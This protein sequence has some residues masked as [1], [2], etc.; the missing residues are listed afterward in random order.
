MAKS[1]KY[2][3]HVYYLYLKQT[4]SLHKPIPTATAH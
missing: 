3:A 1:L 2:T 4:C